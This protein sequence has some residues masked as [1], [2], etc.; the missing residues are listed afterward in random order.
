M[1]SRLQAVRHYSAP[2]MKKSGFT[3]VNA[4]K[5]VKEVDDYQEQLGKSASANVLATTL[6]DRIQD[7][8]EL[9]SLLLLFH[10]ELAKLGIT[11]TSARD[12]STL[13]VWRYRSMYFWKLA[14]IHNVFWDQ[15]R[16]L[17]IAER[18]HRLGFLPTTIGVLDPI[19]FTQ[20]YSE[21]QSGI[22]KG[23][24]FRH[25]ELMGPTRFQL[26]KGTH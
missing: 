1:F 8:P 9:L 22:Y 26:E 6:V 19:N 15:C 7:K 4:L 25:I 16:L 21:L 23:L 13:Q 10:H 24:D 5:Y 17:D 14:R 11:P 3:I 20:Y 2:Q 12:F 18:A